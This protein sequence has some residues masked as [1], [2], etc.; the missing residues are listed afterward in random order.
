STAVAEVA[1]LIE[2][3]SLY[4]VQGTT[5]WSVIETEYP[6]ETRRQLEA[7][8]SLP[9]LA[10]VVEADQLQ[11][12]IFLAACGGA[13]GFVFSSDSSL[14]GERP[15]NEYRRM[16][17]E[18]ANRRLALVEP[19]IAAASQIQAIPTLNPNVQ[20]SLLSTPTAKLLIV[21]RSTVGDQFTVAP[22]PDRNI[23]I[24]APGVPTDSEPYLLHSSGFQPIRHSRQAGGMRLVLDD[25]S[26]VSLIVLTQDPRV[27]RDMR[28]RINENGRRITELQYEIAQ[29]TLAL[30]RDVTAQLRGGDQVAT[31]QISLAWGELRQAQRGLEAGNLAAAEKKIANA[32][33][34]LQQVQRLQWE[35]TS[36]QYYSPLTNPLT[37]SYDLLPLALQLQSRLAIM[38]PS[39]NRLAG[40][41]MED[42][43]FL[44]SAGWR[45]TQNPAPGIELQ[46]ELTSSEVK[47]GDYALRLGAAPTGER[48]PLLTDASP[49]KIDSA[50][51]D[52]QPGQ[53]LLIRGWAKVR[54]HAASGRS[55]LEIYDSLGGR[56]LGLSLSADDQWQEFSL[57]RAADKTGTI[58]LSFELNGLTEATIDDVSIELYEQRRRRPRAAPELESEASIEDGWLR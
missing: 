13:R 41:D 45:Q 31:S 51:V 19:W 50:L 48:P 34:G 27:Q 10:A 12:Q 38:S 17:L 30:A 53:L 25:R 40:G 7:L 16:A 11:Q 36:A 24:Q 43:S 3:R 49:L 14:A 22:I 42:L 29:Q 2:K 44:L 56:R 46:C 39:A 35:R 4:C 28:R 33:I 9:Q 15:S 6:A 57:I 23:E 8:S 18:L 21:V 20:A 5:H 37:I 52:V 54:A 55:S 26:R 1:P 47:G 58:R 32:M